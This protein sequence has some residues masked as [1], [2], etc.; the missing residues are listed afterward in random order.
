MGTKETNPIR[1]IS[2]EYDFKLHKNSIEA[3]KKSS[4][5]LFSFYFRPLLVIRARGTWGQSK[6]LLAIRMELGKPIFGITSSDKK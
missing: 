6:K 2:T 1:K 5:C 4:A 3:K